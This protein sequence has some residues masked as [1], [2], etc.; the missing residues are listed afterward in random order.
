MTEDA[1]PS[2]AAAA[3][4]FHLQVFVI[5]I[6]LGAITLFLP[7]ADASSTKPVDVFYAGLTAAAVVLAVLVQVRFG[8][9]V[10]VLIAVWWLGSAGWTV[11]EYLRDH[12]GMRLVAVAVQLAV[13]ARTV[14]D[15]RRMS[16]PS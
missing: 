10:L 2:P 4:K 12:G 15:F 13:L 8:R 1:A 6:V 14:R 5:V 9:P 11:R 16:P 3:K 7:P